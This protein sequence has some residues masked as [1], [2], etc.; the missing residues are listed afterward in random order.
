MNLIW[1]FVDQK[2]F[3]YCW[4]IPRNYIF[5][6]SVNLKKNHSDLFKK[7]T[8][9]LFR[10][11]KVEFPEF[12]FISTLTIHHI[13]LY[14]HL[15]IPSAKQKLYQPS[16]VKDKSKKQQMNHHHVRE[17]FSRIFYCAVFVKY[18]EKQM[19]YIL[20]W[21]DAW[22]ERDRKRWRIFF[23]FVSECFACFS[24]KWWF[25]CML[26]YVLLICKML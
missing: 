8:H 11:S 24:W 4:Q 17:F 2:L 12:L 16:T 19:K 10:S 18:A 20:R 5:K 14:S 6:F 7:L 9:D 3:Q 21:S 22:F 26:L 25:Y 23:F 1:T 13:Q 15:L